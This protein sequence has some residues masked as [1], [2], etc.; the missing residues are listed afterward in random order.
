[1]TEESGYKRS[2]FDKHGPAGEQRL[3]IYGHA[4]MVF[5]TV[6]GAAFL[7]GTLGGIRMFSLVPL[8]LTL[9][10][11]LTLS[12]V[13]VFGSFRMGDVVEDAAMY[14]AE[15]GSG[16]PYE[17]QFSEMQALV[18]Q[19]KYTEAL[20]LF[21]HQIAMTPGE[22][23]VRVAAA[24]LYATHGK[25]PKRAAELYREVQRIPKV[26]S[27]HDIYVTNKLA[28]LYLGPLKEPG[29]ALVEFRKLASRYPNS[30]AAKN[31]QLAIA[32]LKPQ[33]VEGAK[34]AQPDVWERPADN[35]APPP[36]TPG[37]PGF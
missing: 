12:S 24:D 6:V 17:H 5:G 30:A 37:M 22:P 26:P 25:D 4:L 8:G 28:D 10:A 11:A 32:N 2:F 23:R 14:L 16:T 1:M 29:R 13:V 9:L 15:G 3:K 36:N 19:G 31:A 35:N 34:G 18:M 7:A 20:E 21:E 33:I 27:G